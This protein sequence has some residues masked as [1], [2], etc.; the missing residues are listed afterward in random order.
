MTSITIYM[1]MTCISSPIPVLFSEVL[2]CGYSGLFNNSF[3]IFQRRLYVLS[4]PQTNSSQSVLSH[5]IGTMSTFIFTTHPSVAVSTIKQPSDWISLMHLG[6]NSILHSEVKNK[7]L[8]YCLKC[9]NSFLILL[10]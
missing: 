1:R 3:W 2:S 5:V 9:F 6:P 7:I 8:H 10:R 4:P